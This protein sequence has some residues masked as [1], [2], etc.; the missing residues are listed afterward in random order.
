MIYFINRKMYTLKITV[1]QFQV[2]DK[3]RLI[4]F[5][6]PFILLQK[7]GLFYKYVQETG[8]ANAEALYKQIKRPMRSIGTE[9]VTQ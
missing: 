6:A 7:R 4:E 2:M 8:P 3:G 1:A 9:M 5:D